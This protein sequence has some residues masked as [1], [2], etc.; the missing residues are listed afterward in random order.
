MVEHSPKILAREE[1]ATT[2]IHDDHVL[3]MHKACDG[4]A[5]FCG[6]SREIR[7]VPISVVRNYITCKICL[8]CGV[9]LS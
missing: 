6:E 3:V 4:F 8:F 5:C 9:R 1:E 2:S 7:D